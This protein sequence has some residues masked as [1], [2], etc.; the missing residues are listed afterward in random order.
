MHAPVPRTRDYATIHIKRLGRCDLR[1]G[2]GDPD[3]EG[4]PSVVSRIFPRGSRKWGDEMEAGVRRGND[5]ALPV[6]LKTTDAA[7]SQGM[8]APP[9]AGKGKGAA[10]PSA[11]PGGRQC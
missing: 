9:E 7:T 4:G 10:F 8:Q 2:A 1:E 3:Y 6:A 5:K 11:P